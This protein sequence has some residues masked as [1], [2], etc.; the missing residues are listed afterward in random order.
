MDIRRR[1]EHTP[2]DLYTACIKIALDSKKASALA[3]ALNLEQSGRIKYTA[4]KDGLAIEMKE[5][6]LSDFRA[7]LNSNLRLLKAALQTIEG[8]E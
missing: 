1:E 6:S 2:S 3:K 5:S 8:L 7:V 4:E